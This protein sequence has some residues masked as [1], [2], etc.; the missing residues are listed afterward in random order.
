M[1]GVAGHDVDRRQAAGCSA[2]RSP[3]AVKCVRWRGSSS[4]NHRSLN[5]RRCHD[6]Q[7]G[8]ITASRPPGRSA[9][10]TRRSSRRGSTTC[11]SEW[12]NTTA[13][14]DPGLEW[15][16]CQ[17]RADDLSSARG[18]DLRRL[19]AT[20][21]C[22]ARSSRRPARRRRG[23]R[24]HSRRRATCPVRCRRRA[25]TGETAGR[26]GAAS[27]P[28]PRRAVRPEHRTARRT[29]GRTR[30]A[31]LRPRSATSFP[32]RTTVHRWTAQ[33]PG[34]RCIRSGATSAGDVDEPTAARPAGADSGR[35]DHAVTLRQRERKTGPP[36]SA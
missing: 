32:N 36:M 23:R 18:G 4:G 24:G 27:R 3:A 13:S 20:V 22:R 10:V 9:A 31:R 2:A 25:P 14:N 26:G 11:S 33:V 8:T 7:F 5:A 6:P 34:I 15:G 16:V 17:R 28:S 29:L 19:L 30:R 35:A 21:R 12:R 1:N